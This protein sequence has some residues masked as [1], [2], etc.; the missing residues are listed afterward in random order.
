MTTV[1]IYI[2]IYIY[3]WLCVFQFKVLNRL[4]N[5]HSI[6]YKSYITDD[7][8]NIILFPAVNNNKKMETQAYEVDNNISVI[9]LWLMK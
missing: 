7:H 9:W 8:I 6:W 1:Y 2:Y 4:A 5:F 3:V